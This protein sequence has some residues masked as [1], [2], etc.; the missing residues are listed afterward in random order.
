MKRKAKNL[1]AFSV[2]CLCSALIFVGSGYLYL[3]YKLTP[4]DTETPSVPYYESVPENKGVVFDICG[5]R[6]LCYMD[7]KKKSLK[8]ILDDKQT[9]VGERLLGYK[10]DY[11]VQAN[12][13][14]LEKIIDT[15]GGINLTQNGEAL[16]YTGVQITDILSKTNDRTALRYEIITQI[17]DKI[18]ET[19]FEKTDFLYII[20][21]SKT[22]LTVPDCYFW[23]DHIKELSINTE[24]L[25]WRLQ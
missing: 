8:I 21:N 22:K 2:S 6:T 9:R 7:F 25:N 11:E 1:I 14:I 23:S 24:F 12:Y 16:R 15:V 5:D 3:D 13:S 19:G 10:A 20:E 17:V 18:K 4:T